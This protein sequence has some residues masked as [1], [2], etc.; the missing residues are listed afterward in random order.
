MRG[1]LGKTAWVESL[2]KRHN[3]ATGG[4]ASSLHQRPG[5]E[6][7]WTKADAEEFYE[8]GI[9]GANLVEGIYM[10]PKL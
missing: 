9:F 4:A 5:L 3:G 8:A 1:E 10:A 2:I 7:R 6:G